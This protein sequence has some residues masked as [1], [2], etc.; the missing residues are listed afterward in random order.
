M[1]IKGHLSREP[2]SRNKKDVHLYYKVTGPYKSC[3]LVHISRAISRSR[4][5]CTHS[6]RFASEDLT[7][8]KRARMKI[9]SDKR[10]R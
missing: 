7:S 4:Q 10:L 5:N 8:I 1:Q 3:E 9:R 2:P 6:G